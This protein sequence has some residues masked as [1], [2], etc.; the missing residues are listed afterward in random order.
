MAQYF[1]AIILV[2]LLSGCIT[3]NSDEKVCDS[4]IYY[5]RRF[6][7]W[8]VDLCHDRTELTYYKDKNEIY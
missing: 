4:G 7:D 1:N 2:L 3:Y 5:T 8:E 6:T